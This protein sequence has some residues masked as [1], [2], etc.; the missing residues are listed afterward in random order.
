MA[1]FLRKISIYLAKLPSL[2]YAIIYILLIPTFAWV[3]TFYPFEFYHATIKYEKKTL[4]AEA[5]TILND[6]QSII[7]S[8]C[9][10]AYNAD[11]VKLGSWETNVNEISIHSLKYEDGTISFKLST[12]L[13]RLKP[14]YQE[15]YE[16]ITVKM[17]RDP[18]ISNTD[19][20]IRIIELD[21]GNTLELVKP[22]DYTKLF[23]SEND[24]L[25][26]GIP[27][28]LNKKLYYFTY[29][30]S[31]FPSLLKDNYWR[32]L[33]LSSVTIT[34]LGYGDIVPLTTTT[35]ML[36]S[37]EAIL[38]IIIIGLFPSTRSKTFAF[39]R[40]ALARFFNAVG[41]LDMRLT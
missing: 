11:V 26:F 32:M 5:I 30:V 14:N 18:I 36:V 38:G 35:R 16:S 4:D 29:G 21:H 41:L 27:L 28:D 24:G 9:K 17:P 19:S 25:I 12:H 39:R 37:A 31:G 33:Y 10:K 7:V 1:N 23:P 6:I 2:G 13:K 22:I 40:I 3:Y 8:N 15:M 20:Y 34:T